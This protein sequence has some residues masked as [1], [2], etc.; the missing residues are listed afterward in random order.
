M[1]TKLSLSVADVWRRLALP[2]Q[3]AAVCRCPFHPDRTA[4]FSIYRNGQRWKCF[5]GCGSGDAVALLAKATGLNNREAFRKTLEL[6][7]GGSFRAAYVPPPPR[8]EP[9]HGKPTLPADLHRGSRAELASVAARRGLSAAGMELASSRGL[10]VFGRVC[11]LP[12][13]IVTDAARVLAQARRMDGQPFPAFGALGARKA[14]TLKGSRQ[15]WP[16]GIGEA[17]ACPFVLLVEGGPD[18]LAACHFIALTGS[19]AELAAV[20]MLGA[21]N[22]LPMDALPLFYGKQI[23]IYPHADNAGWL[24]A[25][26]WTGQLLAAGAASVDACDVRAVPPP[27]GP[28]VNDL[29]DAARIVDGAQPGGLLP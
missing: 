18:L 15:G 21:S 22:R 28:P 6:A 3:P 12:C 17:A 29:N 16:L 5:A 8:A 13:W 14:H 19:E 25:S 1:F 27:G 20:A 10:L 26:R 11:G 9:T 24:A 2:G 4:S 23:R 7:S